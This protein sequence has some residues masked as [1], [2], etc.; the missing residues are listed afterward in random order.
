MANI[1]TAAEAANVL[2]VDESDPTMLDM[3]PAVDRAIQQATGR[4]WAADDPVEPMAKA[5]ARMLLT[6]WY[7]NPA[8][9][10]Q[11]YT[12]LGFGL[13]AMLGQLE[14]QA[15]FLAIEEGET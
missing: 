14:A 3:L 1:L 12:S 5:A 10:A 4:D 13:T 9:I 11:G 8:M 7:E 2:R 15:L 6:Q